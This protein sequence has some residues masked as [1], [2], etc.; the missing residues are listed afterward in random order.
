MFATQHS[1]QMASEGICWI[2]WVSLLWSSQR[3]WDNSS[4]ETKCGHFCSVPSRC[5]EKHRF[6]RL[7]LVIHT[8]LMLEISVF[9]HW[10]KHSF[11]PGGASG[12]SQTLFMARVQEDV[13]QLSLLF[14]P[15]ISP[16]PMQSWLFPLL[17]EKKRFN[18]FSAYV[19]V[20]LVFSIWC[21]KSDLKGLS[22]MWLVTSLVYVS[23]P[24]LSFPLCMC[25][26]L[27]LQ[28]I[29]GWN[30]CVG[31][32]TDPH[33]TRR[34]WLAAVLPL[35]MSSMITIKWSC[36]ITA[37]T[38]NWLLSFTKS[39]SFKSLPCKVQLVF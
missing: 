31:A 3:I 8:E 32:D 21:D 11:Y 19:P 15:F 37:L 7:D 6:G 38:I 2:C 20:S 30:I 26:A 16:S 34:V 9:C 36:F 33:F 23:S 18:S 4:D 24:H 5:S 10:N 1:S 13:S 28:W 17:R 22:S 29:L 35:K 14:V 39:L 25:S 27:R 12:H